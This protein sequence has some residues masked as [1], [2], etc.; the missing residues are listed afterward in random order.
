MLGDGVEKGSG[1]GQSARG[2]FMESEGFPALGMTST[3]GRAG[4]NGS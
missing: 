3:E 1:W 4:R 2:G